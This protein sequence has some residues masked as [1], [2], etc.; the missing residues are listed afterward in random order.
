M[1]IHHA[2]VAVCTSKY[3]I[4]ERYKESAVFECGECFYIKVHQIE[5][6]ASHDFSNP[7]KFVEHAHELGTTCSFPP[8]PS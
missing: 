3:R 1:K 4:D 8:S 6:S 7:G 5:F 2:K